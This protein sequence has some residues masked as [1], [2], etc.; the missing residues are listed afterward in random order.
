MSTTTRSAPLR[1]AL[2]TATLALGAVSGSSSCAD[3]REG[4][5]D[6]AGDGAADGGSPFTV[7]QAVPE[8]R[9]L[10]SVWGSDK[11]HV[12]A[13]GSDNLRYAYVGGQ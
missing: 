2:A 8:G 4:P 10:Y 7:V 6:G 3:F 12:F 13:V 11:D 1:I 5:A 9:A